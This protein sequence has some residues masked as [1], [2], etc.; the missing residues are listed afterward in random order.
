M[1]WLIYN[2]LFPLILVA[3]LP[4][5]LLR[6]R[7][8]GGYRR[9]F[10][11]R[12]GLYDASLKAALAA[13]P[14]IW[15]HAVSVGEMFVALKFIEEWRSRD[16]GVAFAISTNTS[17]GHALA[18]RQKHSDDVLVYFPL[19]FPPFVW[20]VLGLIRPRLLLLV[21]GEIWPNLVRLTSARG[22][23]IALVNGR[24]SAKSFAGYRRV[25]FLFRP[26]MNRL[27]RLFVQSGDDAE[28]FLQLGVEPGRVA[29]I[30]SAKYDVALGA[31]GDRAQAE[32]VFAAAGIP[33]D[34]LILLGGS[35][36]AGEEEALLDLYA[37][38]K[39]VHPELRLVLVPR[40]AERRDEVMAAIRRR[41]LSVVQRSRMAGGAPVPEAPDVLLADTT[42]E[43]RHLYTLA[44]V[45][46]VGK[47]LTQHGGQN[48][49]E[50]ASCGKAI[51]VGPNMENFP[52]VMRDL[53]S[54]NAIAQISNSDELSSR[55]GELL[56]DAATR[57]A[58]G[59]RAAAVVQEKAG[60]LRRTV[61]AAMD[62]IPGKP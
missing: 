1:A 38:H 15:I 39:A 10:L 28:R 13:R 41:G 47:S 16:A 59:R 31:K 35:T 19:D 6:M 50:P 46:F 54:E 33:A 56:A 51:V 12:L 60:S 3:M 14:R 11:Q 55:V 57:A 49:I 32:K 18:L 58:Y 5:Y 4:H 48:P 21:E 62:L 42:G 52:D 7:R 45:I 25:R 43:L 61:D 40:H 37:R 36:W 9:G 30:G 22:V 29:V 23:P 26:V 17:T 44:D 53:L 34:S 8:R 24:M 27:D 20:R 2:L